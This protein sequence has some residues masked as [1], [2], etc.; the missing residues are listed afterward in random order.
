MPVFSSFKET[1]GPDE[2]ES[3]RS[4]SML[5]TSPPRPRMGTYD[6]MTNEKPKETVP[7]ESQES[8]QERDEARDKT[9]EDTN[10]AEIEINTEM[11]RA[12]EQGER[13]TVCQRNACNDKR[14][15]K[16]EGSDNVVLG[17]CSKEGRKRKE[18]LIE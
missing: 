18:P 8:D 16:S 14:C 9:E 5:S 1:C 17:W 6:D 12:S 3:P 15:G 11:R 10:T 4:T 2:E 13:T 7:R